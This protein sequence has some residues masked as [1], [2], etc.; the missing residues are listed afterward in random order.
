[1]IEQLDSTD[2]FRTLWDRHGTW[3]PLLQ[4]CKACTWTHLSSSYK[5]QRHY[6]GLKI[7]ACMHSWGQFWTKRYTPNH[8]HI[9]L[10]FLKHTSSLILLCLF[11][12]SLSILWVHFIIWKFIFVY[13][14]KL[15]KENYSK[16]CK[17][18]LFNTI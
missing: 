17:L 5:T 12:I 11:Y 10:P 1:M 8:T 7:T 16:W 2:A 3:D 18:L 6:V 13:T 14:W 4:C 15:K 9:H